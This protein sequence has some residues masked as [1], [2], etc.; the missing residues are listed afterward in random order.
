MRPK[1]GLSRSQLV[2]GR[3]VLKQ[4]ASQCGQED[5]FSA[6]GMVPPPRRPLPTPSRTVPPHRHPHY[7]GWLICTLKGENEGY[8]APCFPLCAS[9]QSEFFLSSPGFE[10]E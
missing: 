7:L 10:E 5:I 9:K 8:E 4:G 1:A 3:E 6:L 2:G